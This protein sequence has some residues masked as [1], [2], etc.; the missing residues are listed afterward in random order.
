[1]PVAAGTARGRTRSPGAVPTGCRHSPRATL[2]VVL[3]SGICWFST[4]PCVSCHTLSLRQIPRPLPPRHLQ[5]SAE[6]EGKVGGA[7][8]L[9]GVT[10]GSSGDW[11][12]NQ[13]RF[14]AR[15]EERSLPAGRG[16]LQEPLADAPTWA[17]FLSLSSP[18]S[19]SSS[20]A[21]R[22][23]MSLLSMHC[24]WT[25]PALKETGLRSLVAPAPGLFPPLAYLVLRGGL[26][27]DAVRL[28][29]LSHH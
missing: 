28:L 24:D 2:G 3:P 16:V 29:V 13:S 12:A 7:A 14:P 21:S 4:A 19:R 6:C 23:T 26:A 27:P 11:G 5:A 20:Q 17:S 10:G 9:H 8:R 22:W 15:A 18:P 1:M 25:P